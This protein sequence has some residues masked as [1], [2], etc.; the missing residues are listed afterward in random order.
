MSH[1]NEDRTLSGSTQIYADI[2]DLPKTTNAIRIKNQSGEASDVL[3]K[4]A[5]TNKIGWGSVPIA[6]DTITTDMIRDLAVTN[7]KIANTTITGGKLAAD[8][9]ISTTGNITCADLTSNGNTAIGD[10]NS[11]SL[12][13]KSTVLFKQT[14]GT[15]IGTLTNNDGHLSLLSLQAVNTLQAGDGSNTGLTV[16]SGLTLIK[17][18]ARFSGEVS[19]DAGGSEVLDLNDHGITD[20]GSIAFTTGGDITNCDTI[21]C[22]TLNLNSALTMND[23]SL[24]LGTGSL[25]AN[26]GL[27]T[28]GATSC[29]AIDTNNSNITAG[30]GSLTANGGINTT[31]ATVCR[32]INTQNNAVYMGTGLIN[33]GQIAITATGATGGIAAFGITGTTLS[34]NGGDITLTNCNI[35]SDTNRVLPPNV[36]EVTGDVFHMPF[37][38]GIF[39]P[40]DDDADA[41]YAID[42]DAAKT[43]GRGVVM[44]AGLEVCGFIDIP[45]GWNATGIFL[46]VR[47]S[48]GTTSFSYPATAPTFTAYRVFTYQTNG[49]I[50]DAIHLYYYGTEAINGE[51]TFYG[52]NDPVVSAVNEC[53]MIDVN[54]NATDQYIGGGYIRLTKPS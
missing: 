31:G 27:I 38:A 44:D 12:S 26:G 20:C 14:D 1:R 24:N 48:S 43:R 53:L 52:D 5:S 28:T 10:N 54:L 35:L 37:N 29:R 36:W 47:N 34:G 15:T 50:P 39:H 9:A 7:A 3:H 21:S 2:L 18:E 33:C 23:I 32:Q 46:D 8:I 41:N 17:G 30:S 13:L 19:M 25:T 6:N 40:N 45:R 16:G 49:T 51:R 11:D 22:N 42:N 4:D